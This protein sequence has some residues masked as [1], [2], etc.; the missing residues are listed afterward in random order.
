MEKPLLVLWP[1]ADWNN[2][3]FHSLFL[4]EIPTHSP[5][6]KWQVSRFGRKLSFAICFLIEV[7]VFLGIVI[8]FLGILMSSYGLPWHSNDY[9]WNKQSLTLIL[10]TTTYM[11]LFILFRKI[12]HLVFEDGFTKPSRLYSLL[13]NDERF[14]SFRDIVAIRLEA[15]RYI[16]NEEQLRE[17]EALDSQVDYVE[18][19]GL[20]RSSKKKRAYIQSRT[21]QKVFLTTLDGREFQFSFNLYEEF[22]PILRKLFGENW[23]SN[24]YVPAEKDTVAY[25]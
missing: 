3:T 21:S 22:Y 23:P 17:I 1:N 24:W 8:L 6:F 14:V 16:V 11:V 2:P 25:S 9:D 7:V 10:G 20:F 19:W 5:T 15:V 18:V 12:P 4:N 13:K